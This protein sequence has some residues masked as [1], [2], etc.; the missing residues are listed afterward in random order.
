[1]NQTVERSTPPN[2]VEVDTFE[3]VINVDQPIT[4]IVEVATLG[5]RG[6]NGVGIQGVQ[7]IIG[8]Q[9]TQ[10]IQGRQGLNGSGSQGT[11]GIIGSQGTAGSGGS[12]DFKMYKTIIT[13]ETG[14]DLVL[15]TLHDDFPAPFYIY[16]SFPGYI[17]IIP[18]GSLNFAKLDV[19][20]KY[21]AVDGSDTIATW[22]KIEDPFINIYTKYG[23][24]GFNYDGALA[25]MT[26]N[27]FGPMVLTILEYQ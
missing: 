6:L 13:Q 4:K 27:Y 12:S 10:G 2:R 11:Q 21:F 14:H 26:A 25:L 20:F 22:T 24:A 18:G 17:T 8:Q 5:P 7:G 9:G 16:M 19:D 1:M 23:V 3:N 15:T